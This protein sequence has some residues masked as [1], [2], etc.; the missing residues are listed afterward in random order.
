MPKVLDIL[1]PLIRIIPEVSRPERK[2]ALRDRIIWTGIVL[3]IYLVMSEIPLYGIT[4]GVG[5]DPFL[6][7]RM[8]FAAKRGTLMEL[9]IGPIVTAGLIMQLLVGS[10]ILEIDFQDP[11]DRALYTGAQKLMALIWGAIQS[12]AYILGGAFGPLPLDAIILVFIQLMIA[13]LIIMLLDEMIQ[14]GWG[15][16]SG[17]S[18]FIA[19]GIAQQIAWQTFSPIIANDGKYLGAVLAFIQTI[20]SGE[21]IWNAFVRPGAL[22][23]MA[24]LITTL[25]IFIFVIYL[26]GM[27]IEV[28]VAF[29]KY[30][31]L[32]TKIPLKFLYVSN[33]PIIFTSMLFVDLK[34]V[35]LMIWRQFNYNNTNVFLNWLGMFNTTDNTPIGG[36]AYYVTPPTGLNSVMKDPLHAIIYTL[37]L[38]A[39]SVLFAVIWV[40]A[41]GLSPR[42]QAQ[43]LVQAGLQIPGFRRSPKIIERLLKRYI[44]TLTILSGITV[45]IIAAIADLIGAI[46]SGMGVLLTVGTIYQYWNILTQEQIEELYPMIRR[47]MG[48]K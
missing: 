12:L 48:E 19:T 26:E 15:I 47:I 46:G 8:L 24:G 22:P 1:E 14:K 41:S 30:R 43:Q 11:R 13:T 39:S 29:P 3:T 28:P 33:I 35:S 40:E 34:I 20:V 32:R 37:I 42:D 4:R 45:A 18:L 23:G 6:Y 2:L 9:G 36:L 27:R 10:G 25:L 16:G 31:G 21:N 17:V 5:Y 44:P 38:I 7:M